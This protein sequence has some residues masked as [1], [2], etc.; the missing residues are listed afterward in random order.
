VPVPSSLTQTDIEREYVRR[1]KSLLV[2]QRIRKGLFDKQLALI[3]DP[4]TQKAAKCG[5]RAGKSHAAAAYL[6]EVALKTPEALC[7]YIGLSRKTARRIL[8]PVLN[9]FNREYKMG[10]STNNLELEMTFPNGSQIWLTGATNSEDIEKLRGNAYH[11]VIIDE[12]ASFGS[13]FTTLIEDILDPALADYDGTLCLIGSPGAACTGLFFEVTGQPQPPSDW[14][15]HEWTVLDNPK[16]PRWSGKADWARRA[17]DWLEAKRVSKGWH[18]KYPTYLREWLGKWVRDEGSLVYKYNPLFNLYTELPKGSWVDILGVDL[19]HDDPTAFALVAYAPD[20][21][22]TYLLEDFSASELSIDVV[23]KK[24]K[25][26]RSKHNIRRI[27]MDTQGLGKMIAAEI[28]RRYSLPVEPAEKSA[29]LDFIE[30]FNSDLLQG[31][32]KAKADSI[33][34]EEATLLQWDEDRKKE[35]PRFRNHVTDAALYA[36]RECLHW[37]SK[38]VE[39]LPEPNSDEFYRRVADDRKKK[40][41][42]AVKRKKQCQKSQ[43]PRSLPTCDAHVLG[44]PS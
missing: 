30:L 10:A 15:V 20:N 25:E 39:E 9:K 27:V 5:R 31:K 28:R 6:C 16:F 7:V 41:M 8:W 12:C 29:K 43:G 23:A 1:N 42:A 24:I 38:P 2:V 21:E 35:D 4:S 37:R 11:L 36:W 3:D 34:V 33:W 44:R 18:V 22:T 19:G 17:S 14:T 26:Y 13:F 40:A 32:F